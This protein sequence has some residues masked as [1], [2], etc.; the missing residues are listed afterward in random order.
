MVVILSKQTSYLNWFIKFFSSIVVEIKSD[1]IKS[2]A[3]SQSDVIALLERNKG[4]LTI[5]ITS[6]S[7]GISLC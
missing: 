7:G 4:S 6:F 1:S 5:T 2:G 3:Y